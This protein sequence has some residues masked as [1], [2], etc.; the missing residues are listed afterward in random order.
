[1]I[2]AKSEERN[3]MIPLFRSRYRSLQIN[4]GYAA[5]LDLFKAWSQSPLLIISTSFD[6]KEYHDADSDC[7]QEWPYDGAYVSGWFFVCSTWKG[8]L[9]PFHVEQV[10]GIEP[11]T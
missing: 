3:Q 2:S 7:K 4:A 11:S 8:A 5:N 10:K 1:M 9:S 6:T